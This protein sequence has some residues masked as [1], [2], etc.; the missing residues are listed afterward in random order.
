MSKTTCVKRCQKLFK[1][2]PKGVK[3]RCFGRFFLAK[4]CGS[5]IGKNLF[6]VCILEPV[7]TIHRHD[8]T[9]T[10][11]DD[12]IIITITT[13][14]DEQLSSLLSLHYLMNNYHHHYQYITRWITIIIIIMT[15]HRQTTIMI[16]QYDNDK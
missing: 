10:L 15:D 13:L 5:Q 12:T 2:C 6:L 7:L 8:I 1:M 11:L 14:L 9:T 16:S 4:M 3:L